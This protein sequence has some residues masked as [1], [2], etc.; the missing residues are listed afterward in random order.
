M[1]TA[2]ESQPP[3]VTGH[4][5][6]RL[7]GRGATATVW[8]G[9]DV[10]GRA[11][12]IKI[13]HE[14]PHPGD[15]QAMDL[16]RHVLMAV[17][18]D[19][20][21]ALR[22]VVGLTDGR[23]ALVFD[24][25]NGPTLAALIA[26]RGHLR[27]G[28]TVTI[29]TPLCQAA[30]TI[31]AA[32]A[33]HGDLST[34]N[35]VVTPEGRPK[36]LDLGAARLVGDSEDAWGTAGFVAPEVRAGDPP[37]SASDVFSLGAIAWA[38]L[39]GNGAPDTFERLDPE[40]IESHVG[41]ELAAVV[42]SAIDPDPRVRPS[43]AELAGAIYA[44]AEAE[45][46][47]V[48]ADRDPAL[49]LTH[50]IRSEAAKESRRTSKTTQPAFWRRP[51]VAII[52]AAV[53]PLL[54]GWAVVSRLNSA[55]A[56][57]RSDRPAAPSS[58]GVVGHAPAPVIGPSATTKPE[59]TAS[60]APARATSAVPARASAPVPTASTPTR[61]PPQRPTPTTPAPTVATPILTDS[62]AVVSR[63]REV[64]SLLAAERA[65][66]LQARDPRAL[67]AVTVADSPAAHHDASVIATLARQGQ[68]YVGL[69]YEIGEASLVRRTGS[70][71]VV[72][73]SVGTAAYQVRGSDG[74]LTV[75]PA[76]RA[77]VVDV[78][79][80]YTSTGWRIVAISVPPAS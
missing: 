78:E 60:P 1:S 74:V 4:V 41:P 39:T 14:V 17:R 30:E 71:A 5:V 19:H 51:V 69:R 63:P 62:G 43:A 52:L 72:R 13:P 55:A 20:V 7:I 36:V 24:L 15:V 67:S 29:L 34:G 65:R 53:L 66:V 32:G 22:D 21:V 59:A 56:A 61:T 3:Q 27:P 77:A 16:E 49:A 26:T 64:L 58:A 57:D 25:V 6:D 31:H 10:M 42:G 79:L 75:M 48:V 12:A 54:L 2:P 40:T 18:H 11:V 9:S 68:T 44:A 33:V 70:T 35:V 28:E 45:P 73:A 46:V 80:S 50:R 23:I 37:T 76:E 8:A 38:C 47:E